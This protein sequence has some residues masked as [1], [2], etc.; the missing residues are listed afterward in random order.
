MGTKAVI[1]K[2]IK[3]IFIC[4]LKI[5][6][7]EKGSLFSKIFSNPAPANVN[8]KVPGKIPTRVVHTK[9]KRETPKKAGAILTSQKGNKGTNLKKSR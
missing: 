6:L 2:R 4:V 5:V 1:P 3:A 8:T 7:S 9:V